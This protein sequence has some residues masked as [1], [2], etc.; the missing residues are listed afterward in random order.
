MG[1]RIM[2]IGLNFGTDL[3][4]DTDT[5]NGFEPNFMKL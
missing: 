3:D 2:N 4:P 1:F 5:D